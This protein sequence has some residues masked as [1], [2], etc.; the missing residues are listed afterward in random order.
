MA[1]FQNLMRQQA[2][3]NAAPTWGDWGRMVVSSGVVGL[4]AVPKTAAYGFSLI[5]D[6]DSAAR[7]L[8]DAS[9]WLG[10]RLG[11]LNTDISSYN[12]PGAQN[13]RARAWTL[14]QHQDRD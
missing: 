7:D 11:D 14:T 6:E 1:R 13:L 3:Q 9:N 4:S 8:E 12:S 2:V 5:G 10:D